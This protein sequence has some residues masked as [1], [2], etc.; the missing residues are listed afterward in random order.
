MH[1]TGRR[2]RLSP[3]ASIEDEIAQL[4]GLDLRGSSRLRLGSICSADNNCKRN[5]P[6]DVVSSRTNASPDVTN[7][8]TTRCASTS[9]CRPQ[10]KAPQADRTAPSAASTPPRRSPAHGGVRG[11]RKPNAWRQHCTT[12]GGG[13][14]DHCPMTKVKLT[15]PKLEMLRRSAG[16]LVRQVDDS[17]LSPH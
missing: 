5:S 3:K 6:R 4:R 11:R 14:S 1:G 15:R 13:F 17:V 7:E 8:R 12:I 9:R 16:L 10:S 2:R